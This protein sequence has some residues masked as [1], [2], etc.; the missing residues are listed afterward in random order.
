VLQVPDQLT[1]GEAGDVTA[2]RESVRE[3]MSCALVPVFGSP[4]SVG[5]LRA[6]TPSPDDGK[7]KPAA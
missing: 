5:R 7:K 1:K 6:A 2:A 3:A 4:W